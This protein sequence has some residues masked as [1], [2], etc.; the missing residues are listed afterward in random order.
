[1]TLVVTEVHPGIASEAPE[2]PPFNTIFRSEFDYVWHSLRR[3]GVPQRDLE[4]VT[5]DV[6]FRVYQHWAEYDCARQLRPWVFGFCFRLASDY[7]R[8][9]RH[10]REVLGAE[11]EST[12][13]GPSAVERL[14][15][16]EALSLAQ[17]ALQG[18]E[19]ERRAVFILHEI[20]ACPM[21]E[22]ARTL[23]LPLNTA[24]S[25]L[26]LARAEFQAALRR[27]RLKRGEP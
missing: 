21:P 1:M 16:A 18:V 25:R 2:P 27:E 11:S 13:P 20:D 24:Y 5:H 6:F 26:R 12:D 4:D 9:L 15:R 7:R 17:T 8:R 19:I 22:I 10:Q 3:L 14:E 23:A